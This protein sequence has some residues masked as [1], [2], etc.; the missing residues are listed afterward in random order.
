MTE[1][2]KGKIDLELGKQALDETREKIERGEWDGKATLRATAKVIS[3]TYLEG[4]IGR[5]QFACDEP[6]NRGGTDRAATPLEYFLMG[7]AF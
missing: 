2:S 7:A 6:P 3:G 4:R 1:V 5:F